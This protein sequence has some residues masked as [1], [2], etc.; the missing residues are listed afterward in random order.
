M[1]V[2]ATLSNVPAVS[3]YI[4]YVATSGQTVYPYPFP[5]TQDADLVVV[6]NGTTLPTDSGYSVS[7]VGAAN[8]GNVTLS[9]GSTGGDI[10]TIFRNIAISRISQIGQNSGFSSTV[11][12]AEYNQIYL[13][14]QQLAADV[15]QCLQVPNTNNPAPTTTLTPAAY[16]NKYLAFDAN[17]NPTPAVLTSSGSLT[18]SLIAGLLN[19]ITGIA[20]TAD[21]VRSPAEISAGVVPVNFQHPVCTVDRYAT[22]TTP[23]TTNMLSAI[24]AAFQVVAAQGGG[25]VDFLQGQTY[26]VGNATQSGKTNPLIGLTGLSNVRVNGNGATIKVNTTAAVDSAVFGLT[27]PTAVAFSNLNFTDS[28]FDNTQKGN[29]TLQGCVGV[30]LTTT[31]TGNYYGFSMEDCSAS[32]CVMLASGWLSTGTGRLRGLQFRNCRT[33]N[34][35][36]GLN[37]QQQ[38]DDVSVTNFVAINPVRA[39]FLYGVVNHTVD[40]TVINDGTNANVGS[41]GLI[42]IKRYDRDTKSIKVRCAVSGDS[43]VWG[44]IFN[45]EADVTSNSPAVFDSIDMD[46]RLADSTV[47][48]SNLGFPLQIRDVTGG[49]EQATTSAVFKRISFRGDVGA[50]P[51]NNTN[52]PIRIGSV[53]TTTGQLSLGPDFFNIQTLDRQ[54]FPGF[55]VKIAPNA[56]VYTKTGDLTAAAVSFDMTPYLQRLFALKIKVYQEAQYTLSSTQNAYREFLVLGYNNAGIVTIN[57]STL[58][59]MDVGA[60]PSITVGTSGAN[61]TVSTTVYSNANAYQRIVVEHLS[62]FPA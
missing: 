5:I 42:D 44:A 26:F 1:T 20:P 10:V 45:I 23:G 61:I 11:F 24:T 32:S 15:A 9:S 41:N 43:S 46:A 16:A 21:K 27:N 39:Y 54:H 7:G 18:G 35:I 40:I 6:I 8:G 58:A 30:Y 53:P 57:Q 19:L 55:A 36:Y 25:T 38:G 37:F 51:A 34:T 49:T 3:P 59:T 62:K 33:K 22:N 47:S 31:G 48:G 2:P 13:I 12:N 52:I 17:G 29:P 56:Y 4:Q 50:W 60:A 14:L 28:G